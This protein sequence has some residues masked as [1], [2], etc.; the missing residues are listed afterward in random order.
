MKMIIC[1]VAWMKH[2]DGINDSDYPINGG[3]YIDKN[4]YGH[5]VLNFQK[6]G[7]YCYGYVQANNLTINISRIEP[8]AGDYIDDVL[9]VWRSRSN[10]GSVV[11]GWYENARVY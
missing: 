1:N 6:N 8:N 3:K 10:R 4:G 5:E 11:I 9:V 7:K 2:Y